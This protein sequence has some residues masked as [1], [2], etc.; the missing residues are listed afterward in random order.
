MAARVRAEEH[1]AE[2]DELVAQLRH[3]LAEERTARSMDAITLA[4]LREHSE[5]QRR[6]LSSLGVT[7]EQRQA[8]LGGR[9]Q[10]LEWQK[11]QL[12]SDL[13]GE[14]ASLQSARHDENVL[15]RDGPHS[16]QRPRLLLAHRH[17]PAPLQRR[18]H[19]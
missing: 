9:V 12:T 11:A 2:Q 4:E 14:I 5:E 10:T 16:L 19:T 7:L 6:E 18:L 3:E 15:M 17:A 8:E 1:A 13:T